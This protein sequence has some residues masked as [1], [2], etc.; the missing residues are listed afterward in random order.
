[1]SMMRGTESCIPRYEVMALRDSGYGIGTRNEKVSI[2]E[3]RPLSQRRSK[4]VSAMA[5]REVLDKATEEKEITQV[6]GYVSL[7]VQVDRDFTRARR[8]A[9]LRRIKARLRKDHVPNRLLSMDEV[10]CSLGA[11]NQV[12]RGMRVV[13]VK[14]IVGSLNRYGDSDSTFLPARESLETK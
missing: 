5:T 7:E 8:K 10:K 6:F 14:K 9:S 12:Y 2:L 3:E 1:V 4:Q 11:F 13:L